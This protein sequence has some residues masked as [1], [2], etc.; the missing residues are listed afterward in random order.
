M[1]PWSDFV[2]HLRASLALH[3]DDHAA[4]SRLVPLHPDG[5]SARPHEPP[6]GVMPRTGAVLA[7][8]YRR[9]DQL[10]LPLTVRSSQLRTHRGEV[11][12]PGGSRDEGESL[13]RTALREC[14][15]ELGVAPQQVTLLGQLSSVYIRPSNFQITPF[16]AVSDTVPELRPHAAEVEAVFELPAEVLLR[17]ESVQ[18]EHWER[19]G[20][21]LRVPFYPYAGHKIWGATAIVLSQLAARLERAY[22]QLRATR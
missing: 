19:N 1:E 12:L 16:V 11:S 3:D 21:Q 14:E 13:D 6:P 8:L 22:A 18:V 20:V 15:E 7:L 17:P 5:T 4:R 2:H 10:L 9:D